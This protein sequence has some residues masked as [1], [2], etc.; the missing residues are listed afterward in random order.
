MKSDS[1]IDM[2]YIWPVLVCIEIQIVL[3]GGFLP[4]NSAS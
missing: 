1:F 3:G 4:V 2:G